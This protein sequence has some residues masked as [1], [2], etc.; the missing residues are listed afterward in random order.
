[1][2]YVYYYILLI[3]EFRSICKSLYFYLTTRVS[4]SK[5]IYRSGEGGAIRDKTLKILYPPK[6]HKKS[7]IA[8]TFPHI[9]QFSPFFHCNIISLSRLNIVYYL[10]RI[11]L[12]SQ[13]PFRK[14]SYFNLFQHF[15]KPS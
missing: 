11:N 6:F 13:C 2:V 1:M 15:R 4:V 8:P 3:P 5:G 10:F 12:T 7:C 14:L 9:R